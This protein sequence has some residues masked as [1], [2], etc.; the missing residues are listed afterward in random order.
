MSNVRTLW[1]VGALVGIVRWTEVLVLGIYT[2]HLTHSPV[3][4]AVIAF[5]NAFPAVLFGALVGMLGERWNRRWML[6]IGASFTAI[7]SGLL[8]CLAWSQK[9]EL[10]HIG[11]GTFL[12]GTVWTME[13]PIR[14]TL[15]GDMAGVSRAATVLTFDIAIGTAMMFLGPLLGGYLLRDYGL[16]AFYVMSLSASLIALFLMLRVND[17]EYG[18]APLATDVFTSLK[19]GLQHAR[20]NKPILGVLVVTIIMNFFGFSFIS[21]IPVIGAETLL[22]DAA[23]IGILGSMEGAGAF[24]GLLLLSVCADRRYFMRLFVGG[25]I[26][27][28]SMIVL[29]GLSSWFLLALVILLIAGLGESGFGGMQASI[30]YVATRKAMRSRVMGLLVVCIGSGP[31][32]ILH[33]GFLASSVGADIAVCIIAIEGLVAMLIALYY[34]PALRQPNV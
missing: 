26:L 20:S 31:I 30:T 19:E 27:L 16:T 22:L 5:L 8:F 23:E 21:M 13:Y 3:V 1:T 7:L 2:Y 34:L 12:A 17:H 10:W 29:F 25:S 14:R 24:V 11:L 33:T 6:I 15:L 18:P 9:I 32:G 28:L 4:V